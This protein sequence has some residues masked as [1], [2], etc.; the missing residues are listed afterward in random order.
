M[1]S[2]DKVQATLKS[3]EE[4][5]TYNDKPLNFS[6]LDFWRWSASDLLSNA[7]RGRFAE[8]IVANA[9]NTNIEQIRDE[10]SAFDLETPEEIKIEVK[11]A[12]YLQ[13]WFHQKLSP[14]SFSTKA[15]FVWDAT[16]NKQEEL[17]RRSADVYVFCLLDHNNKQ[18]VDPLNLNQWKF[19]VLAT[20]E[21]N[22]YKRSQ[23]SITLNSLK[24]LTEGVNY[25]RLNNEILKSYNPVNS[26]N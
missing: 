22:R 7:T 25:E 3:G 6:L 2:L 23:H 14:I 4:K 10:W 16:T 21:L 8:F 13:S 26:D 18:T 20:E 19:Y 5:L 11:S 1:A 24:K 9:T 17:R 15:A 12:A